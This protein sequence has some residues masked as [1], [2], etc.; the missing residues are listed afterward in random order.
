LLETCLIFFFS[1]TIIS[2][3]NREHAKRSRFRKKIL[4]NNLLQVVEDLRDDT[5]KLREELYDA[6]GEEKVLS[7]LNAKKLVEQEKFLIGIKDPSNRVC[8]AP[9]RRFLTSLRKKLPKGG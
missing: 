8:D 3:R 2:Q 4:T 6:I 1:H 7:I 5:E 9:T